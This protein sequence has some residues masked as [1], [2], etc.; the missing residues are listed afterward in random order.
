MNLIKQKVLHVAIDSP[1]YSSAGINK[2]FENNDYEVIQFNWQSERFSNGL[3][4][5]RRKLLFMAEVNMP[6]LFFLH[7]QNP[8]ILDIETVKKLQQIA[9]VVNYTFD[10]RIPEK[11]QWLYDL[12]PLITLTCFGCQEDVDYCRSIGV[13]NVCL[14]QSSCDMDIYR[15]LPLKKER[16]GIVF[17][18]NNHVNTNL[19]FTLAQER[20]DMVNFLEEQYP[21]DFKVHGM[22]WK[23]SQYINPQEEINLYNRSEIAISHNNFDRQG[24]S[25]DRIWRIISTGTFCLTKYFKGIENIFQK[26]IHLDWW[27]N[28]DELK[29]LIDF[30]LN[31]K[32]ERQA[33]AEMGMNFVLENENWSKRI[34]LIKYNVYKVLNV[35]PIAEIEA[36]IFNQETINRRLQELKPEYWKPYGSNDDLIEIPNNY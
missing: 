34:A 24:Y 1:Q 25:S 29:T 30:Y 10:V 28:F 2:G 21:N 16:K 31:D 32:E 14:I 18:G 12:S 26:E 15:K 7:I 19:E 23:Q 8:D 4:G 3:E 11:S 33:I 9:P 20:V 35:I 6:D 36:N 13:N 22:N 27:N 17:I 5:M